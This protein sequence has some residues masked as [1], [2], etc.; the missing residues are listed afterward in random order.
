ML[1]RAVD[2]EGH[3]GLDEKDRPQVSHVPRGVY[4]VPITILMVVWRG[5]RACGLYHIVKIAEL[6]ELAGL[7]HFRIYCRLPCPIHF[8]FSSGMGGIRTKFGSTEFR[9]ML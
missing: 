3:S 4:A 7:G 9:K 2:Y 6:A 1:P 5:G 8:A